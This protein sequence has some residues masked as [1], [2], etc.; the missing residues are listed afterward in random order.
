MKAIRLSEA[1]I[2]RILNSWISANLIR[3]DGQPLEL[4]KYQRQI[5][6]TVLRDAFGLGSGSG[7]YCIISCTRG[8][9]TELVSVLG[10]LLA[11]LRPATQI[12]I[13]A[14]IYRQ[15]IEGIFERI[16]GYLWRNKKLWR[17]VRRIQR[18]NG[19]IELKNGSKILCLSATNP[20]GLL[21]YGADVVIVDEAGSTPR[22]VIKQRILRMLMTKKEGKNLLFTIGTPHI[23]DSYLWDAWNSGDFEKYRITWR[24]AVKEGIMS[25]DEVD[26][27]R[28]QLSED[29]FDIWY[30]CQWRDISEDD[31]F[32]MARV[33]EKMVVEKKSYDNKSL[34]YFDEIVLGCDIA[35]HGSSKTAVVVLGRLEGSYYMIDYRTVSKKGLSW[36]L[37]WLE[38]LVKKFKASKVVID[39]TGLGSGVHDVLKE[40]LEDKGISVVGFNFGKRKERFNLYDNLKY[41]IEEGGLFLLRDERLRQQFNAFKVKY[42]ADGGKDVIKLR[43]FESDIVDA[44]A[45]SLY[46]FNSGRCSVADFMNLDEL[47]GAGALW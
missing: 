15:A 2:E 9:K 39:E 26:F 16:D 44:L 10:L 31:F 46:G 4:T 37:G 40:R 35:R 20:E 24:D 30:N 6:E 8:G 22:D 5:S 17:A 12:V 42:R 14:P 27:V 25:K 19:R 7:K 28:K 34:N 36:Q 3:P 18:H 32:D 13:I 41:Q 38:N 21:G 29:E 45:L 23:K 11:L 47:V 1:R 33:R 43:N